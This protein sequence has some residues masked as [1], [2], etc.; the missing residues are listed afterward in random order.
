MFGV[1]VLVLNI[2]GH[3]ASAPLLTQCVLA[4]K[5]FTMYIAALSFMP[6]SLDANHAVK[7]AAVSRGGYGSDASNM[8]HY[9]HSH[10]FV[11][12]HKPV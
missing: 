7:C 9:R 8:P 11:C 5:W 4:M 1:Q 6:T 10:G 2:S 12:L 3:S